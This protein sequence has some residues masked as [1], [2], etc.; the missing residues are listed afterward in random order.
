MR[1]ILRLVLFFLLSTL[2]AMHAAAAPP[3]TDIERQR[4]AD[5]ATDH[6][7]RIDGSPAFYDLLKN[8][9]GWVSD[10][11]SG[12]AGAA[13]APTPDYGFL[14][15]QPAQ[16]R[17]RVFLIEGTFLQQV[18]FP[19]GDD[20]LQRSGNP[21]WG[22]RVTRWAI[23]TS[24]TDESTVLVFFNDPEG[25][26]QPP[27]AG[28]KVR[29]A[30]RYYKVWATVDSDGEP[31][32][33]PA[34][35]G[36]AR[37]VVAG[38]P[39]FSLGTNRPMQGIVVALILSCIAAFFVV[40]FLMNRRGGAGGRTQAYLENRRRDRLLHEMDEEEEEVEAL[41]ADPAEAMEVLRARHEDSP[42]NPD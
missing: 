22:D 14:R 26:I 27:K 7:D 23:Q 4:I 13:T 40:R 35:V 36:G 29:V 31:F 42:A 21:D 11:F 15:D 33:F 8:A 2:P 19:T 9:S 20:T 16:A 17:G 30:A 38:P 25:A 18:R 12:E 10:D 1:S 28:T 24:E 41:P 34:F 6:D 3:L 32:A 39:R 5:Y 37:E